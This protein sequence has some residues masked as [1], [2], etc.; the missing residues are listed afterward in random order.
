V[1]ATGLLLQAGLCVDLE[2][3]ERI[4]LLGMGDVI[5]QFGGWN[6]YTVVQF[7]PAIK[8]NF[9]PSNTAPGVSFR[10]AQRNVRL[11]MPRTYERMAV[12]YD[13]ILTSDLDLFSFRTDWIEWLT[14]SVAEGGL[15][16]LWLGNV[17]APY[18]DTWEGTTFSEISPVKLTTS[19][20][21]WINYRLAVRDPQEELM[22]SLP[23]GESPVLINLHSWAPKEGAQVWAS[24]DR[25]EAYPLIVFWSA[26]EG[27][28]LCFASK[29]PR[30]VENWARNWRFFNQAVIYMVYRAAGRK[31][32]ED[33][34]LYERV[35]SAF[36]EF[37]GAHSLLDSILSW[38]EK[39]GGNPRQ[40]RGRLDEL[41][42]EKDLADEA[43]LEGDYEGAVEIM[44]Q[45]EAVQDS[46]REDAMKAKDAALFWI[47]V[48]EW[49][50]VLGSC[51]AA[52]MVIWTLMVR[53]RLY[54]D[55]G[56]TRLVSP[57]D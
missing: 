14:R 23:W 50:S 21:L 37:R 36:L 43:Y 5:E 2:A 12:D 27:N 48:V 44:S 16:Y 4:R 56:S 32:P 40:L 22:Q 17:I 25:P 9:I 3:Q 55:V 53:R 38:V 41:E 10:Q 13:F 49:L 34:L 28:V 39:F 11:Y 54:R 45:T 7:D 42:G 6:T 19:L 1:V 29:F 31:L 15:D 57:V 24:A 26:G 33:P 18:D 20:T 52:S 30:G 46:I 35:T 47:Y 51:L 8:A